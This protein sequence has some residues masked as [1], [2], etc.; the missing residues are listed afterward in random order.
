MDSAED[1]SARHTVPVIDRMMEV[2]GVL[3][4]SAASLTIREITV[5]RTSGPIASST[6]CNS[7]RWSGA[8][9]AA[10]ITSAGLAAHVASQVDRID[11]AAVSQPFLDRLA[12]DLGEGG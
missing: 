2:L 7:T 8:T 6:R 10:A 5:P 1:A 4:A 12:A 9:T 11:V 3:E